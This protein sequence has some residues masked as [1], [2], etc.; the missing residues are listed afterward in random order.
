M[1]LK[2][3]LQS[4]KNDAEAPLSNNERSKCLAHAKNVKKIA[5]R[6]VQLYTSPVTEKDAEEFG[7]DA[8]FAAQLRK[9]IETLLKAENLLYSAS[10]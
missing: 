8:K 7:G 1:R 4:V 6:L 2:S 10:F 5:D 9:N 3:R